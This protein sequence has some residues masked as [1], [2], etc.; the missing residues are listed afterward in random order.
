MMSSPKGL[1]HLNG[2]TSKE[3][4]GTFSNYAWRD[5][6]DGNIIFTKVKQIRFISLMNWVKDNNCLKEE[7][8]FPDGTTIQEVIY[9]LEEATTRKKCRK[10]QKKVD[11]YLIT[12][13]FQLQLEAAGNGIVGCFN[14]RAT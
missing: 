13:I 9:E 4:L 14:L 6:E 7:S 1:K 10:E 8:L 5:K 3:I 11:G 12:T 2:E